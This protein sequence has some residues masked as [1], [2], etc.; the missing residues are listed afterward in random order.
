[1][2]EG[3]SAVAVAS[4]ASGAMF[5]VRLESSLR[6][7]MAASERFEVTHVATSVT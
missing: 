5:I 4:V 1:M 2:N 3:C 6:R 7:A